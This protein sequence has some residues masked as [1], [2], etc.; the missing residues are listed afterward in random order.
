MVLF[1][2]VAI[3]V[4]RSRSREAATVRWLNIPVRACLL[5]APA[6]AFVVCILSMSVLARHA[7]AVARVRAPPLRI[8]HW[9]VFEDGLNQAP[10]A[11]GMDAAFT[12]R[13]DALLAALGGGGAGDGD[14]ESDDR[15]FMGFDKARD[16]TR[17]PSAVPIDSTARLLGFVDVLYSAFY[18]NMGGELRF[19]DD[20]A[21][22]GGGAA[23]AHS[24]GRGGAADSDA[25]RPLL[26][27]ALRTLFLRTEQR[28]DGTWHAPDFEYVHHAAPPP[29][30]PALLSFFLPARV[31]FRDGVF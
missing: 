6:V 28:P 7:R 22:D 9:N 21:G 26:R 23:A 30:R 29:L 27:M 15:R 17:V 10:L 11:I 3:F 14:H 4:G 24:G 25:R 8:V 5:A 19:G 1:F 18:H 31:V 16:F 2:T 12:R 13:L 20:G